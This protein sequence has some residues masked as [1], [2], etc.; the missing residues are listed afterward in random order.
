[1]RMGLTTPLVYRFFHEW[2]NFGK[3][4]YGIIQK[5][6]AKFIDLAKTASLWQTVFIWFLIFWALLWAGAVKV[7][8][9]RNPMFYAIQISK[10]YFISL[11]SFLIICLLIYY[12]G[13]IFRVTKNSFAELKKII[14]LWSFSM[15]PTVVWFM[16]ISFLFFIFP[17]PRSFSLQGYTLSALLIGFSTILFYWKLLLYY[18]TLRIGF[19]ITWKKIITISIVF[20]PVVFLYSLI[21]YKAGIFRVPFI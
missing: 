10:F 11:L 15:V 20:F 4:I 1:M 19:K 16:G 9:F 17:P 13:R 7:G 8:V 18:L 12:L 3:N 5:P 6:H 21:L 2:W 14:I